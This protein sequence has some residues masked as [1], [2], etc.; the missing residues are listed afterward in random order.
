MYFLVYDLFHFVEFLEF[1]PWLILVSG[2][3]QLHVNF[4]SD[5]GSLSVDSLTTYNIGNPNH[6]FSAVLF[7]EFHW[8]AFSV[9]SKHF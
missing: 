5:D 2:Y 1:R 7:I 9:S 3:V 8:C 4:F 6:I